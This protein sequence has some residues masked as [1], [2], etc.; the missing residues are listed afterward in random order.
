MRYLAPARHGGIDYL[1]AFTVSIM[2]SRM[3]IRI[4]AARMVLSRG[5]HTLRFAMNP[6]VSIYTPTAVCHQQ[7][8]TDH[9]YQTI[10][11]LN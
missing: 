8:D 11:A 5:S 4:A 3:N 7:P 10:Y 6:Y 2:N 1:F 9:G